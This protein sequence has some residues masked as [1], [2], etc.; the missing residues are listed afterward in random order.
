MGLEGPRQPPP[1]LASSRAWHVSSWLFF[2][3]AGQTGLYLIMPKGNILGWKNGPH[4]HCHFWGTEGRAHQR[5]L[6]T[7][8][9]LPSAWASS[10]SGGRACQCETWSTAPSESCQEAGDPSEL[11]YWLPPTL[12]Q[13]SGLR[14]LPPKA[15]LLLSKKPLP[16]GHPH[17]CSS[18][19]GINFTP[20]PCWF[21]VAMGSQLLCL[22]LLRESYV[23]AW[24]SQ[25]ARVV[26]NLSANAGDK[27]D[28]SSIPWLG[29]SPD[30]GN[31]NPLQ[32]SCLG[33]PMN[34][35]AWRATVHRVT[36]SQTW[37][38]R[39]SMQACSQALTYL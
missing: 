39:L 13:V 38:K 27:R 1:L 16:P 4:T 26:K 14:P 18:S 34:R 32:Y 21:Q 30:I 12:P 28:P 8:C 2:L 6:N 10:C 36:K 37:L 15:L 3:R 33:N 19:R 24:A 20:P 9:S 23:S 22:H 25:L 7:F 17:C 35:G 31:G 5:C 29:R 11:R